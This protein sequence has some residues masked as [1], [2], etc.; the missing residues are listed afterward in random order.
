MSLV[1]VQTVLTQIMQDMTEKLLTVHA[2]T[3]SN[4]SV[5]LCMIR[6]K[7]VN[8][9]HQLTTK[10]VASRQRDNHRLKLF[11]TKEYFLLSFTPC[12]LVTSTDK[13]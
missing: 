13:L 4:F 6:D 7:T 5:K 8:K 2:L 12:L 3:V 1:C 10:I 11:L 9:D